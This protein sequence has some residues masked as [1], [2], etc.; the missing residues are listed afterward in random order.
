M[1]LCPKLLALAPVTEMLA[2]VNAA[3]PGLDSVMGKG[4]ADVPTRVPGKASGF[5]LRTACETAAV[6]VNGASAPYAVPTELVA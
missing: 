3:V 5:G 6:V 1:L 2:M 4:D